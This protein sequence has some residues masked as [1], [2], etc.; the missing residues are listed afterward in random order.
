MNAQKTK[1][2]VLRTRTAVRAGGFSNHNQ[3][4]TL[5]LRTG[6]TAGDG[7]GNHNQAAV[8]RTKTAVRAGWVILNHNQT[9]PDRV[10]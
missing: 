4:G 1:N 7:G 5:R 8:L 3:A 10:R 2:T 9:E 6:V